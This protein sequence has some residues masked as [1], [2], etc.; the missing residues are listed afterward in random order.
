[1][2]WHLRYPARYYNR[3]AI[4]RSFKAASRQMDRTSIDVIAA[5]LIALVVG[6]AFIAGCAVYY[7]RQISS[8]RIPMQWDTDGQPAWFAPRLVGLWFSFGVTAALSMFL[9]VLALHA[10]QKL[11]ALIVATI[12]V[13]GTNMWVQ[14]YHLKRVVRWQAEAPAN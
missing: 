2:H 12:S 14:V 1:M 3:R 7:G 6:L 10:P 4:W 5:T 13:I 11:T 8:R 9:L